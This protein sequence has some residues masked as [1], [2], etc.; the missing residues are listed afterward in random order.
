VDAA[1]DSAEDLPSKRS[2]AVDVDFGAMLVFGSARAGL[3]VRNLRQP[4]FELPSSNSTFTL[5]RH[6]R[7]GLAITPGRGGYAPGANT[8][9]GLDFDLS[10]MDTPRG[11]Q[12][13]LSAGLEQWLAGHR[14]GARGGLRVNV[15]DKEQRALTGGLSFGLR[16]NSY[17]DA[18]VTRGRI[19]DDR[20]WSISARVTF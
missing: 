11:R 3:V 1:L 16:A 14:I 15:L 9:I 7:V 19:A 4:K 12:R 18:H 5:E 8:N 20:G 2:T 6:A 17:V 13:D 10:R